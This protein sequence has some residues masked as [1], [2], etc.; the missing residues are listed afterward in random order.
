MRNVSAWLFLAVLGLPIDA[1]A[2][3]SGSASDQLFRK[4]DA[5]GG[6]GIRFG[7]TDDIVVPLGD[8]NAEAGR[9]WTAHIKTSLGVATTGETVYHYSESSPQGYRVTQDTPRPAALS[10][11]VAYQFYE[12]VFMHPYV[13]AGGRLAW[14]SET[15]QTYS[16]AQYQLP[17][18]ET[19]STTL[20]ARPVI[21]G[22]FKSYFKNGRAFMRSEFLLAVHL[23]GSPHALLRIGAGVD[24]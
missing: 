22:G 6:V 7:S 8:W 9:Y 24:F 16:L 17:S 12:N 18:T 23:H 21:G 3:Q 20:Q 14:V 4:W 11:T 13:T 2:Q 15:R 1:F 19:L 10:G 5:G